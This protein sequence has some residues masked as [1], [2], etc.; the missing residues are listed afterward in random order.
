MTFK[1]YCKK[2]CKHVKNAKK[3]SVLLKQ[4][5][6]CSICVKMFS[7]NDQPNTRCFCCNNKLRTKSRSKKMRLY[8][9]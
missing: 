6:Y 3:V 4:T 7:I 8:K 2:V 5:K 9:Y 1:F